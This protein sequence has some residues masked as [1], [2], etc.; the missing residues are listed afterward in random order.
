MKK[1]LIEKKAR[2]L[3]LIEDG[4]P[5]FSCAVALGFSPVGHKMKSGDGKT[6]E[7][8]Y[9][10]CLARTTGRFGRALGLSYPS[11]D[12]ARAAA[13]DG[14][15]DPALVPLFLK[16]EE[17]GARP[18][19]GT[20]LGGEIYIHGGGNETD[21]TAG[22]VALSDGDMAALFALVKVGAPVLIVP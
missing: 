17:T 15:L 1:I 7:G 3:T 6:P 9:Y 21:W 2:R 14:R 22:C 5:M 18:P 16:A 13:L 12:D 11:V 19:W 10:V 20:P 4:S 8:A